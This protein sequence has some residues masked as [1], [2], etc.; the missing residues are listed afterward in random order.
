MVALDERLPS[1][2]GMKLVRLASWVCILAGVTSLAG[3]LDVLAAGVA[4]VTP[5]WA[6]RALPRPL[7]AV[8]TRHQQPPAGGAGGAGGGVGNGVGGPGHPSAVG[9]GV[10]TIAMGSA[11]RRGV[12]DEGSGDGGEIV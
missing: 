1:G 9:V 4:A 8:L 12:Q 7:A 10:T 5:A 11:K 3:G 6:L 2:H